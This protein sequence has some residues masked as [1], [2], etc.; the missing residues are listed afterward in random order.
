VAD[1]GAVMRVLIGAAAV[2]SA[3]PYR[4]NARL[5]RAAVEAGRRSAIWAGTTTW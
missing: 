5:A 3:V 2:L 1:A 4:F